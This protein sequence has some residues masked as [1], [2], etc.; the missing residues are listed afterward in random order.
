MIALAGSVVVATAALP[1][2]AAAESCSY[3]AATKAVTATID[4]GG[5]ATLVV[6]GGALLGGFDNDILEA[7]DDEADTQIHGGPGTD[8]AHVDA[9]I[10]PATIAVETVIPD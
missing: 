10:D 2:V 7:N 6:V 4:P 5:N 8:T 1:A 3:N 9:G